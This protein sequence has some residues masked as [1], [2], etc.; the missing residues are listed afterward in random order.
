MSENETRETVQHH[1]Y[2]CFW[3]ARRWGLTLCGGAWIAIGVAWLLSNLG[4]ITRDWWEIC[5][6]VLLI[7][8][9]IAILKTGPERKE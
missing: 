7:A 4:W 1:Y 5:V 9:G 3:P 6:P 2:T 8:W